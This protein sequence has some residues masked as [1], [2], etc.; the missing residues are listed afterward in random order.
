MGSEDMSAAPNTSAAENAPAVENMPTVANKTAENSVPAWHYLHGEPSVQGRLK[1]APEYFKVR[2]DLGFT[3]CGEGEH[4]LLYI[5][6]RGQNTQWIARELARVAGVTQ[7]EVTWAGLKDRHAV[8]EQWFGVH[9]P[10][11][12]EPNFS[13]LENADVQILARARHN[14]KLKIGALKG[15]WFE[16]VISDLV[17]NEASDRSALEARLTAIARRGVPNYYG[18]QRFGHHFGNIVQARA[19]FNGRKVKDRNKR[20]LYLSAAR[21]YLFNLAASARLS[22][23]L[24]EQLLNGDCLML[25][26]TQSFFTINDDNPL[27]HNLQARFADEDVRLSAPLWG[28]GRLPSLD[29]AAELEL[30]ALTAQ[31]DLCQG[32]E[33]QGLKQER[34]A[35]LLKPQDMSWQQQGDRLQLS[36]WLPAGSY[37]TSVVRELVKDSEGHE[38]ISE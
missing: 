35:L 31:A 32:L 33:N 18:E 1:A 26:G 10:G 3:P 19:M 8:T 16:L 38:D 5:R 22:A 15:N 17:L 37:A 12:A 21:S 34:R 27:D 29:A 30:A 25:A 11:K 4:I 14:K 20:S 2:E 24:G 9:L 13:S 7:R 23:G 6:K 28:R 36:F